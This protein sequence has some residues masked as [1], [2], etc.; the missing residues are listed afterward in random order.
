MRKFRCR[1][2]PILF[3]HHSLDCLPVL[4]IFS[5]WM[6]FRPKSLTEPKM[7]VLDAFKRTKSGPRTRNSR[8]SQA[9]VDIALNLNV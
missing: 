3:G 2:R 8:I 1:S 9:A 6:I 4:I 7:K 5:L